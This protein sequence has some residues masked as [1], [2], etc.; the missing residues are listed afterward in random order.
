MAPLHAAAYLPPWY[1]SGL[2]AAIADLRAACIHDDRRDNDF[3]HWD[4]FNT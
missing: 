3:D 1:R 2:S 4:W